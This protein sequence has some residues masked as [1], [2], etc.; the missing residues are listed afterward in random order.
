MQ[1]SE[2]IEDGVRSLP[3]GL[4]QS[5]ER[6]FR[7]ARA[8]RVTAHAVDHDQQHRVIG[9]RHCDSVLIFLAV[10]D[11]AHIRGLDLQ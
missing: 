8:L 3:E 2:R 9:G 6:G 1:E 4:E 10:A 7:G 11:E 5:R